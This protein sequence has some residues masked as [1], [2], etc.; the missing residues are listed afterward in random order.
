M[1][2]LEA[3]LFLFVIAFLVT[4]V[5]CRSNNSSAQQ[6]ASASAKKRPSDPLK[7]DWRKSEELDWR[8]SISRS[9]ALSPEKKAALI[10]AIRPEFS[11]K[12][13][14]A[15]RVKEVDLNNDRTPEVIA[16]S[17]DDQACGAT[18]NCPL[19]VFEWS[20]QRYTK[21]LEAQAQNF[22][23]QSTR[24][25]G[26]QDI[27]AGLHES[28]TS[29]ELTVYKFDGSK[30]RRSGC[31]EVSWTKLGSDGEYHDLKEPH[32]WPCDNR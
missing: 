25:N 21:L 32:I 27:V 29:A 28:A 24:T 18:G 16:Q 12:S 7:W 8:Q 13:A 15:T 20:N 10:M 6:M 17:V 14:L 23:I 22:T 31:Y 11:E 19:W 4:P 9:K 30:Y 3:H 26:F 1:K 2:L 5:L